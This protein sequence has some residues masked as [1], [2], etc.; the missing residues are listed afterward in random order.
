MKAYQ[1]VL[2]RNKSFPIRFAVF[3]NM[4]FYEMYGGLLGVC[5]GF[6]ACEKFHN[7]CRTQSTL[8]TALSYATGAGGA[9]VGLKVAQ[10]K[11]GQKVLLYGSIATFVGVGV[12]AP[13]YRWFRPEKQ[14]KHFLE[15]NFGQQRRY[16]ISEFDIRD[17]RSVCD[18][19]KTATEDKTKSPVVEEEADQ[20]QEKQNNAD[21]GEQ[22]ESGNKTVKFAPEENPFEAEFH[23]SSPTQ[24][25]PIVN[26]S[27]ASARGRTDG[28]STG[29]ASRRTDGLSTWLSPTNFEP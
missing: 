21:D 28:L 9:I 20:D 25:I 17:P 4:S 26:N 29:S 14:E 5:V 7:D 18:L 10:S 15:N 6:G 13:I 22:V 1:D 24:P 19:V 16:E 23:T 8:A 2:L 3:D 27:T 11:I 12:I